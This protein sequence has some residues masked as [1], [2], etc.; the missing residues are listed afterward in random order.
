Q[1]EGRNPA[2]REEHPAQRGQEKERHDRRLRKRDE[3]ADQH[4]LPRGRAP[5]DRSKRDDAAPER[6]RGGGMRPERPRRELRERVR[7]ADRHLQDED[8]GRRDRERAEP[9]GVAT[10]PPG[11]DARKDYEY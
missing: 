1:A 10:V 2:F 4:A 6:A 8:R 11:L 9:R 3:V 7:G 5:R